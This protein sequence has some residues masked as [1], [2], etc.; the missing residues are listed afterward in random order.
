MPHIVQIDHA[1]LLRRQY[2][3]HDDQWDDQWCECN[4]SPGAADANTYVVTR[5][6]DLEIALLVVMILA[7]SSNSSG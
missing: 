2:R 7:P 6:E 3:Y 5:A 4:V 1:G